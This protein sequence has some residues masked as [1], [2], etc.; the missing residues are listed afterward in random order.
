MKIISTEKPKQNYNFVCS[1]I[2]CLFFLYCEI[3]KIIYETAKIMLRLVTKKRYNSFRI[4]LKIFQCN[5]ILHEVNQTL[6]LR[7]MLI[8]DVIFF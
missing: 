3:I 8:E 1:R 6:I 5:I 4:L 2:C 7:L